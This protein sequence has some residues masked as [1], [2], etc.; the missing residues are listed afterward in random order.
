VLAILKV[1]LTDSDASVRR[2]AAH[3]VEVIGKGALP[4]FDQILARLADPDIYVR[5]TAARIVAI[6]AD[7]QPDAARLSRVQGKDATASLLPLLKDERVDL[8]LA[9]LW[10]LARLGPDAAEATP[11]LTRM[12]NV[13]QVPAA[14][15]VPR[16]RE[17]DPEII[18]GDPDVRVAAMRTLETIVG[19][20]GGAIQALP[21][22]QQAL[23]DGRANY[24]VRQAA[25]EIIGRLGRQASQETQAALIADLK[26]ALRDP[27]SEVVQAAAGAIL[28]L[29]K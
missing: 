17:A 10:A 22:L 27:D 1:R 4:L 18:A 5:W 24:R 23:R 6:F 15:A 14:L 26:S 29:S 3:A 7:K 13:S 20:G 2:A 11:I 9:A 8:R 21:A 25:A 12:F 16:T 28:S 19:D